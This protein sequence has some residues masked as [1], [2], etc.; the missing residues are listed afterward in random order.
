MDIQADSAE[1]L[2]RRQSR[3]VVGTSLAIL[4][5]GRAL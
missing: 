5:F 1:R 2:A 4:H 3:D